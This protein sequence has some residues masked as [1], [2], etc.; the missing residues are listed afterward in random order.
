MSESVALERV[1]LAVLAFVACACVL[2]AF[3][4]GKPLW[5]DEVLQFVLASYDSAGEA[6]SI[7]RKTVVNVNHG[8]TGAYFMADYWLLKAFGASIFWTRFPTLVFSLFLYLAAHHLFNQWRVTFRW[9]LWG[10]VALF[11]TPSLSAYMSEA[12]PYVP[13]AAC[14]VGALAYYF[15]PVAG[16]SSGF[17]RFIGYFSVING[18]LWHP[19]FSVYWPFAIVAGFVY[20]ALGS[21]GAIG[22]K[23]ILEFIN[24]R[25]FMIGVVLYFALGSQTWMRHFAKSNFNPMEW[26]SKDL[27]LYQHILIAHFQFAMG[28]IETFVFLFLGSSVALWGT[29]VFGIVRPRLLAAQFVM[30]GALTITALLC[31]VSYRSGYWII[32][33]Q[34]VASVA[35]A[36]LASAWF[37]Q[38]LAEALGPRAGAI[39]TLIAFAMVGYHGKTYVLMQWNFTKSM[40]EL[41]QA[42]QHA[43][44]L[45]LK[46][47]A[48]PADNQQW[49]LLV[50]AACRQGGPLPP[51]MRKFYGEL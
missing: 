29:Q 39:W 48:P 13:L 37:A 2:L 35:I 3:S 4:H 12:R 47:V 7:F 6:W 28:G 19:Y 14:S 16:R 30:L 33:R 43:R 15:T 26:L 21:R 23:E 34:W 40:A 11:A 32:Q 18:A 9:Q 24:P 5:I 44:A 1:K 38:L 17:A 20:V 50:R 10:F 49:E 8:Q 25:L 42:D 46:N 51:V 45:D 31:Y 22:K 41:D 36:V 27:P